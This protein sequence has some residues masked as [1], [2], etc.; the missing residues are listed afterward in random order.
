MNETRPG[1]PPGTVPETGDEL[2]SV[3]ALLG[4]RWTVPLLAALLRGGFQYADMRVAAP[5]LNDRM[6]SR[7]LCEL[8]AAGLVVR[9]LVAGPPA[10]VHYRLTRS[11]TA[12]GPAL[13][14]FQRWA[15]ENPFR[16]RASA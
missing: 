14:G 12:L 13:G 8:V 10:C 11:G 15:E 6:L 3:F 2:A 7:R 9:E 1:T 4:K 16:G 5:G